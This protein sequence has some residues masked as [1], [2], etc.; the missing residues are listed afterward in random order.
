MSIPLDSIDFRTKLPET[1][2]SLDVMEITAPPFE[3]REPALD[4]MVETL[5]LGECKTVDLPHGTAYVSHRGEVEF[6]QASGAVWSRDA[7]AEQKQNNEL[8]QWP[9]LVEEK[10]DK[11]VRFALSEKMSHEL[12]GRAR[13][14]SGAAEFVDKAMDSG[15]VVLD[16]VTQISEKGEIMQSGAGGATVIHGFALNGLPVFGAGAKS[17]LAFEPMEGE[18]KFVGGLHVWRSPGKG[19]QIQMPAVEE[20]LAV[21]LLEDPELL[22]YAEKGGKITVTRIALGY[23]ALPAMV[24]QRYLFPVF[25]VQGQVSQPDDKLGYFLFARY[26]HAAPAESYKKADLYAPYLAQMN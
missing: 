15:R 23:M 6:F 20:A 25:D 10:D 21:G 11:G 24:H 26:H 9:G 7:E 13:E 14:L 4:L 12:L 16:Q 19:R 22:R 2:R 3:A 1:P 5:Q 8:R 18:P 17:T